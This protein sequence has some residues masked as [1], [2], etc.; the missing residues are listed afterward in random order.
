MLGNCQHRALPVTD[1]YQGSAL[2]ILFLGDRRS[3]RSRNRRKSSGGKLQ[4]QV[5]PQGQ[6]L[7]NTPSQISNRSRRSSRSHNHRKRRKS[8]ADE[9]KIASI[10]R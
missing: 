3:S 5:S 1:H 10:T 2:L 4:I 7:Q 9:Q 6:D 8:S